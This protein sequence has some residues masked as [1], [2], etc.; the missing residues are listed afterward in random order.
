MPVVIKI[1]EMFH[2]KKY[3]DEFKIVQLTNDTVSERTREI[4]DDMSE[5]LLERIKKKTNFQFNLTNQQ[6]FPI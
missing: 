3:A 1:T 5:Q 6:A 4:S 2:G